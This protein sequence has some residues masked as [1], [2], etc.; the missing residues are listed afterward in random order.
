MASR[1]AKFQNEHSVRMDEW[2]K[3]GGGAGGR[4]GQ[5]G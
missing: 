3:A 1:E 4:M 2:G 5:V